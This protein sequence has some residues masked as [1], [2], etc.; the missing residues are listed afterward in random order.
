MNCWNIGGKLSDKCE[1]CK[2]PVG[3]QNMLEVISMVQE[4]N[5]LHYFMNDADVDKALARVIKLIGKPDVPPQVATKL[6]VELQAL[7]AKFAIMA[8]YYQTIGRGSGEHAHK[9]NV[10][11]TLR[12]A[13]GKLSDALKYGTRA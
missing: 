8:T 5:N 4:F 7:S 1:H 9:K 11:Y 10:C 12:D 3:E 13:L 6:V 2:E